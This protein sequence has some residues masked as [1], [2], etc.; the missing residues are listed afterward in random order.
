MLAVEPVAGRA[1]EPVAA[2]GGGRG[3]AG[4]EVDCSAQGRVRDL[5]EGPQVQAREGFPERWERARVQGLEQGRATGPEQRSARRER[6][7]C[8]P[9]DRRVRSPDGSWARRWEAK[10]G[11][12]GRWKVRP[13]AVEPRAGV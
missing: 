6:E 4:L 12:E 1:A 13:A 2:P 9:D 3:R 7:R 11:A 8:A 5:P 10:A